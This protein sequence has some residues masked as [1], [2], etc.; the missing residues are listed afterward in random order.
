MAGCSAV[1]ESVPVDPSATIEEPASV[2]MSA[3]SVDEPASVEKPAAKRATRGRSR[4]QSI[5]EPVP[6]PAVA[7]TAV[8]EAEENV[9]MILC[10]GCDNEYELAATGL[11]RVPRGDWYCAKC[12]P[13]K[14]TAK[15]MRR[16][17]EPE[18]AAPSLTAEE[19]KGMKVAELR[20]ALAARGLDTSGV[21]AKLAE[22]LLTTL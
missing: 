9:T 7:N 20:A 4:K 10:D 16:A 15:R 3:A 1:Q 6:E 14:A 2:E 12:K 8:E 18:A 17:A 21:K 5:P 22:R 11:K 19:V 13:P